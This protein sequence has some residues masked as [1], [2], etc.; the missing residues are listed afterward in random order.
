MITKRVKLYA[1]G[2]NVNL[3]LPREFCRKFDMLPGDSINLVSINESLILDVSSIERTKRRQPDFLPSK[4]EP[5]K[6]VA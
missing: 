6:E 1:V 2:G 5:R 3:A 4:A